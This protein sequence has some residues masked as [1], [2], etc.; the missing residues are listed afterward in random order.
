[1]IERE[2]GWTLAPQDVHVD[3][4][5]IA[6]PANATSALV[7]D[8]STAA[9]DLLGSIA[10]AGVVMITASV[11]SEELAGVGACSGYL[12]PKPEQGHVTAVSFASRK[13]PHWS[14]PG[15]DVLRISLG[16]SANPAP[17]ALADD[18]LSALA[19]G[20]VGGH[21][22]LGRP[23]RADDVRITRW[24]NA[25][26]QYRPHHPDLVDRIDHLVSGSLPLVVLAGAP[27]RGIGLPA[28]IRDGQRAARLLMKQ[29]TDRPE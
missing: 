19:L 7:R 15:H 20:E 29:L 27:Y 13:W 17:M 26:P 16:H 28:C 10:Y 14:N 2:G 8:H 4:V 9:A 22:G 3:A 24:P 21:L 11:P 5:V 23:L 6:C 1:M 25:F 12:V 18:Q